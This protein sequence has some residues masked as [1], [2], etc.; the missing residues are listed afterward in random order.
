M[1]RVQACA[2]SM[3]AVAALL[4]GSAEYAYGQGL[5]VHGITIAKGCVSPLCVGE[6]SNCEVEI[7]YNDDFGDTIRILSAWD[8]QDYN[9]DNVRIPA[10]GDLPIVAVGGNT[11]CTVAGSLPCL[12]GPAGSTLSGLPGNDADGSV[13]FKQNTYVIEADDP[14]PLRD[15]ATV[16]WEDLCDD[17]ETVGCGS[18]IVNP[19][20]APASTR[21]T[22][23]DDGN[24]CTVDDCEAG[25]CSYTP[26][27]EIDPDYCD[28]NNVCTQDICDEN[29]DGCCLYE[30]IPCDPRPCYEVTCDPIEGCV[31][32]SVCEIDPNYCDD[33]D[34]CTEDICDPSVEGCC[35]YVNICGGDG[36]TPGFWKQR[37]HLMYWMVYTPDQLYDVV[38][39]VDAPGDY[40]LLEAVGAGGGKEYALMRH[41]VAALLNATSDEVNYAYSVDQ[42][43]AMVQEAYATGDFNGIKD[44]LEEENERGCTVDKS[45]SG[46]NRETRY[47]TK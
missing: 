21:I 27:C 40:T 38:F 3:V 33:G 7:G 24:D 32:T 42:I 36:C 20:P 43:I 47:R 28:D 30:D 31:Y 4:V 10:S 23:C 13:R 17:P 22:R 14:D 2:C 19:A 8:V 35:V 26:I 1:K 45:M 16:E 6:S 15:Q 29:V 46:S 39:G 41:S 25:V 12:I 37:H 9:G 5:P 11:T 44:M 34:P 18:G